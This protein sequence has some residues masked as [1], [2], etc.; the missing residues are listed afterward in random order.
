MSKQT[1]SGGRE[2]KA[3]DVLSSNRH[4]VK[5]EAHDGIHV[6]DGVDL[7]ASYLTKW[8]TRHFQLC[9]QTCHAA[10]GG[11]RWCAEHE[12][13]GEAVQH[14]NFE[15]NYAPSPTGEPEPQCTCNSPSSETCPVHMK[16]FRNGK[17]IPLE[18]K[19]ECLPGLVG[20]SLLCPVHGK[21]KL[22]CYKVKPDLEAMAVEIENTLI[23]P[24]RIM[25]WRKVILSGL[26]QI[27]VADLDKYSE[28]IR[29]NNFEWEKIWGKA[30]RE[31]DQARSEVER[32][33]AEVTRLTNAA[34]EVH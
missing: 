12:P 18:E 10:T 11:K 4:L 25:G 6:F 3:G 14:D 13:K 34:N 30:I 15:Q 16:N 22:D 9:C 21:E 24:G 5:F 1:D 31:R 26:Q 17:L 19:C 33:K 32:L 23:V 20:K 29:L 7:G 27:D 8:N 28:Q 2:W